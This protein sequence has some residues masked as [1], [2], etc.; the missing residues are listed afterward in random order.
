MANTFNGATLTWEVTETGALTAITAASQF[1]N[2]KIRKIVYIPDNSDDD[3]VFQTGG[4]VNAI[5]LKAGAT[6]ESPI[7][8]DFGEKGKRV[9]GIKCSTIDGGTAYVYLA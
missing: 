7:H 8:I 1:K 5:V 4:S 6:D 3:L 9:A 2:P